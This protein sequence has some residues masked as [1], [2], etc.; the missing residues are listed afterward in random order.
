MAVPSTDQR[1]R[2][3]RVVEFLLRAEAEIALLDRVRPIGLAEETARLIDAW[4]RRDE[5]TPRLRYRPLAKL[6]ALRR[7]LSELAESVV[8]EAPDGVWY[9]E[10]AKELALEARLVETVGTKAFIALACERFSLPK[11]PAGLELERTARDWI[12]KGAASPEPAARYRS[13]DRRAK[14]SLWSVLSARI[15]TLRLRVRLRADPELMSIAACGEDL[16]VVRAGSWL[17]ARAAHRI[18]EHEIGGHLL[19]RIR[20]KK[21]VDVLR[22]GCARCVDEEEGRALLLEHRA[23]LMDD[24]RRAELGARHLACTFLRRGAGFID[25]VRCLTQWGAPTEMA[26]RATLRAMRG[27]GL[28]REVVYLPAMQRLERAFGSIPELERSFLAGRA[29]LRYALFEHRRTQ[30]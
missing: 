25:A 8:H 15:A 23:G 2:Q 22:S 17:S 27:G 12:V 13:D 26:I 29:S 7:I 28:G 14:E 9:A 4:Q 3:V 19:P 6:G 30:P 18:A 1:I 20:S 10:R 5:Q 16:I 11:G 24:G 21:R